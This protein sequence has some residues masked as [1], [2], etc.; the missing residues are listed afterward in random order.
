MAVKRSRAEWVAQYAASHH[1]RVNSF[2]HM[3]GI[4]MI[5]LSLVVMVLA[6]QWSDI[7]LPALVVFAIGWALQFIGHAIE[8][9]KPEFLSD[10]RFLLVGL[11]WWFT[12]MRVAF[13]RRM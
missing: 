7:F 3:L 2:C 9:K 4:P 6:L 11:H 12:K 8:G 1:N 13:A 10:W 5:A